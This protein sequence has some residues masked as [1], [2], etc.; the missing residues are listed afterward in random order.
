[1]RI[2]RLVIFIFTG[3]VALLA[4]VLMACLLYIHLNKEEF[5]QF[6]LTRVNERLNTKVEVAGVDISYWE[7]F[8]K[9][10]IVLD[11]VSAGQ[12]PL[13]LMHVDRVS[14]SF[15]LWDFLAKNY[16]INQLTLQ[17]ADLNLL[18]AK[19]GERNFDIFKKDLSKE[20][21]ASS[22]SIDRIK[23]LASKVLYRDE[24]AGLHTRW[25]VEVADAEV[26]SLNDPQSFSLAIKGTNEETVYQDFPYLPGEKLEIS[27]QKLILSGGQLRAIQQ[28]KLVGARHQ[29][30]GGVA[31]NEQGELVVDYQ[32]STSSIKNLLANVPAG[33]PSDWPGY[34]LEGDASFMGR[35]VAGKHD[36]H[37][38]VNFNAHNVEFKYPSRNLL[39]ADFTVEGSVSTNL[40]ASGSVL[41]L[42]SLAGRMNDFPVSGK[43]T[44]TNLETMH[45]RAELEGGMS[46]ALFEQIMPDWGIKSKKGDITYALGFDGRLDEKATGEWLL[47]GEATLENASFLWSNYHLPLREW[48]G[49]FLFNDRDVAITEAAGFV[50][51]SQLKVNGLLRNFHFFYEPKNHLLLVEG[52]VKSELLDL[53]ELLADNA[54]GTSGGAYSLKI[55]PRL[56]LFLEAEADRILLDRFRGT[57]A[58]AKVEIANRTL[59]VNELTFNSLGGKINLAGS[60]TDHDGDLMRSSFAGNFRNLHIDSVFYV[61][62][63]FDQTWL[64]SR[65]LKG[66]I[67]ADFDVDM[68]L[69]NNLNFIPELLRARINARGINGELVKFE[70]MQELSRLVK[71]DK[72][73]R[74]TF[75]ELNNQFLIENKRVIIPS[76]HIQ[77]NVSNIVLSGTHTFDQH[78]DYRLK[79]PV[80]NKER[81]RDRDEAFGAIEEDQ[82]GN[83]FAHVKITGTTDN[84]KVAYD[85]K[86]AAK[87]I[88]DGIK[89]ESRELMREIKK[90]PVKKTKTLQLREDDFFE[91]EAD[92]TATGGAS[93]NGNI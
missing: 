39:F 62:H 79:V 50:G 55:T 14:F 36:P 57:A 88:V 34:G 3:V 56:Q 25:H 10:S 49:T 12:G 16:R 6:F 64:Q 51:N 78:I 84:Y 26:A 4:T 5:I 35:Y 8:P 31:T 47:D 28:W 33:W 70:P 53:N 69:K 72:L 13:P 63:D 83:L 21:T 23:L 77:S 32:G 2:T 45:T 17:G 90:E 67:D 60:L 41:N 92:S 65:H 71:D 48:T 15:G 93:G 29:L 44:L 81:K 38:L 59:Y 75:G 91:F 19:S 46:L 80:F 7:E 27:A 22:V 40:K 24:A 58:H 52:K 66:Q 86:T 73:A 11:D 37:L 9:V 20:S 54:G 18:V 68:G 85:T 82:T 76:M 74:L 89:N 43:A 30:A 1:M 87:T 61:F 42:H